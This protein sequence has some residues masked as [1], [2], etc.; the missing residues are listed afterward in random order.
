MRTPKTYKYYGTIAIL[1]PT[2]KFIEKYGLRPHQ[3]YRIVCKAASFA[4][5]CRI[6]ESL[7]L[8]KPFDRKYTSKTGNDIEREMCDKLGGFIINTNGT[9]YPSNYVNIKEVIEE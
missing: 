9:G 3:Q 8:Y 4:E 1:S 5:V 6:S 7:G 2:D